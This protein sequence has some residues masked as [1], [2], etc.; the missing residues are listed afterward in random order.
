MKRKQLQD[1]N[2]DDYALFTLTRTVFRFLKRRLCLLLMTLVI[3]IGAICCPTV[4][5]LAAAVLIGSLVVADMV[6]AVLGR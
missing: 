1:D 3:V 5:I 6:L 4:L 2:Q